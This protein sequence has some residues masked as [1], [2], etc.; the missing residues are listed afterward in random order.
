VKKT[1]LPGPKTKEKGVFAPSAARLHGKVVY[2][3]PVS[4]FIFHKL[5]NCITTLDAT[6]T[7]TWRL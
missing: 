6:A 4:V 1:Q 5:I 7:A 2:F 3:S